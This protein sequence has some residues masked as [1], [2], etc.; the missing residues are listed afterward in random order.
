MTTRGTFRS[1]LWDR[2]VQGHTCVAV[3]YT[4]QQQEAPW[5]SRDVVEGLNSRTVPPGRR[6]PARARSLS[7]SPSRAA[8]SPRTRPGWRGLTWQA[9][10]TAW[11]TQFSKHLA[12]LSA[13]PAA[14]QLMLQK[15]EIWER[16]LS[17]KT[18]IERFGALHA[19]T[20]CSKS[21]RYSDFPPVSL[22]PVL[23]TFFPPYSRLPSPSP[24]QTHQP[25]IQ[26][27]SGPALQ[28][29]PLA[30]Q[31]QGRTEKEA[32]FLASVFLKTSIL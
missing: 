15:T 6:R 14:S 23:S 24:T 10:V 12:T 11:M 9:E 30:W 17:C 31:K 16:G 1:S 13:E 5:R 20:P 32:M 27:A 28:R 29:K 18:G 25:P 8:V 7:Q 3:T 4:A 19:Q 2:L 26:G 22:T 21:P